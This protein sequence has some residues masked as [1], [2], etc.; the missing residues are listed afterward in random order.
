MPGE[1]KLASRIH[2][3][4][5]GSNVQA[6][7]QG[8][9]EEFARRTAGKSARSKLAM[10]HS[11]GHE[12]LHPDC[13]VMLTGSDQYCPGCKRP[14]RKSAGGRLSKCEDCG[15]LCLQGKD[16]ACP[17]CGV[18]QIKKRGVSTQVRAKSASVTPAR[19]KLKQLGEALEQQRGQE[20]MN[21]SLFTNVGVQKPGRNLQG[22]KLDLRSSTPP[23]SP[24]IQQARFTETVKIESATKC[25]NPRPCAPWARASRSDM[26]EERTRRAGETLC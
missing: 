25:L 1:E 21:T 12:C 22:P 2:S 7:I 15:H 4:S 13:S 5:S 19:A 16:F 10:E 6:G 24:R 11:L 8:A 14:Q 17:V 3:T 18:G 23:A 20:Q 26:R 9:R